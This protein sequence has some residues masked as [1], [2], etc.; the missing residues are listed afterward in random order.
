VADGHPRRGGVLD[1]DDEVRLAMRHW[2]LVLVLLFVA[3]PAIARDTTHP[4]GAR[5]R[6]FL[7]AHG[8]Q[9]G[10]PDAKEWVSL[11]GFL[12]HRLVAS[13]E[14]AKAYQQ[15]FMRAHPGDKA[16]WVEGNLFH[17]VPFEEFEDFVVGEPVEVAGGAWIVPVTFRIEK[18][19]WHEGQHPWMD[20]YVM[21]LE[22]GEW[23]LTDVIF[24]D[25]ADFGKGRGSR[26]RM[27]LDSR[28][29]D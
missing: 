27:Q 29:T 23:K 9:S 19:Y 20:Q 17:S 6:E 8:H 5:V 7:E 16:P 4:A 24:L 22:D 18:R 3:L 2:L 11:R 25:G 12:G 1:A 15:R 10:L 28:G 13:L 21:V 14:G 26:L